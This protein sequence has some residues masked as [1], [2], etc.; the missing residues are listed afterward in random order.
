M[1]PVNAVL[2][3]LGGFIL[4]QLA[5]GIVVS[6]RVRNTDDYWLAGRSLGFWMVMTSVFATWFGAETCVSSAGG[7]YERGLAGGAAEPFGYGLCIIFLGSVF[8]LPLYRRGLTT[9]ADFYR[10][11]FSPGVE[12]VAVVIL[13]PTSI[14]WAA[15]QIR[16]FG[17]VVSSTTGMGVTFS[18]AIAALVA[19]VYTSLGGLRAD[20]ITD[21]LQG[22]IIIL[23]LITLAIVIVHD[24]GG[25]AATVAL[26]DGERLRLFGGDMGFWETV[27][28]WAVPVCG[29]VVAQEIISRILAARSPGIARSAT[30]TG[31]VFY[32]LIGIIPA[33]TGLIGYALLPDLDDPEQILPQLARTHLPQVLYI[34]FVGALV[35]AILSTVDSSL[36]AASALL[37]QNLILPLTKSPPEALR[38]WTARA[39]VAGCGLIAFGLALSAET[40]YG[41]VEAASSFGG[42]GL[43]VVLVFGLFTRL[44]GV[45]SAF[46]ALVTGAATWMIAGWG[47]GL[48]C[49]YVAS[50][51]VATLAYLATSLRDRTGRTGFRTPAA[52]QVD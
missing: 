11:R 9:F 8:A 43:F 45:Q 52:I 7:M 10:G 35:S 33:F 20:V 46:A 32:L 42:A 48:A 17:Q 3:G 31:G 34:L 24:Q 6:R 1:R 39:A 50:L 41:L 21:C 19:M 13:A 25:P 2:F 37:S 27:E 18:I 38:L 5:I 16:A 14:L 4:L 22:V 30:V 29:S 44:G 36:L 12:R 28:T 23:G 49:P 51:G 40:I 15:A 26:V 47:L